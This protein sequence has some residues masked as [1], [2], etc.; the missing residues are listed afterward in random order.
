MRQLQPSPI[1]TTARSIQMMTSRV[2]VRDVASS[3]AALLALSRAAAMILSASGNTL[4]VSWLMSETSGVISS[5]L[6][7]HCAKV[8]L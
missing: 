5:V 2:R 3:A 4:S 8:E 7:T 6:A 1:S